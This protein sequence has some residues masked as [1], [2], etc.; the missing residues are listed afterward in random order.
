MFVHKIDD[1]GL[2]YSGLRLFFYYLPWVNKKI[3]QYV[4]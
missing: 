3:F 4:P 1:I 2:Y